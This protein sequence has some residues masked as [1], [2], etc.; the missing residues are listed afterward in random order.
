MEKEFEKYIHAKMGYV[1]TIGNYEV[2]RVPGGV[3][4]HRESK[5]SRYSTDTVAATDT[6]I[7]F[8]TTLREKLKEL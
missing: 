8:P 3:I 1:E 6:Y 5:K 7:R 2:S 4:L